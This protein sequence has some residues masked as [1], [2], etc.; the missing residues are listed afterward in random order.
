MNSGKFENLKTKLLENKAW[1][2]LYMFKVIVPNIE[3]NVEK[4]KEILPSDGKYTFNHT[5]NHNYVSITCIAMMDSAEEIIKISEK[6][7]NIN[8]AMVL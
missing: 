5:K 3:G 6:A 7:S 2:L 8:G 1:P 4:A